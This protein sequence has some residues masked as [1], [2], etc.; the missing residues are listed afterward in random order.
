MTCIWPKFNTIPLA[1]KRPYFW[2]LA[3]CILPT[4]PWDGCMHITAIY[5]LIGPCYHVL[6]FSKHQF[7]IFFLEDPAEAAHLTTFTKLQS[8]FKDLAG[9]KSTC[10]HYASVTNWSSCWHLFKCLR[11]YNPGET[12]VSGF[13]LNNVPSWLIWRHQGK[14]KEWESCLIF[15]L[16]AR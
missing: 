8:S 12:S 14:E 7:Q 2:F 1:F 15:F 9:L 13:P 5:L 16:S 6:T 11:Q 3:Y 4:K 10:D